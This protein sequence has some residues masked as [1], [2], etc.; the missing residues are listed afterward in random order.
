MSF[1]SQFIMSVILYYFRAWEVAWENHAGT[2][3]NLTEEETSIHVVVKQW[4][5]SVGR[6][7]N[8]CDSHHHPSPSTC[9]LQLASFQLF[10]MT[11]FPLVS[12]LVTL[13]SLYFRQ[14]EPTPCGFR[15]RW[16]HVS[17][18]V[19]CARVCI[20]TDVSWVRWGG[21]GGA[22]TNPRFGGGVFITLSH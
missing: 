1:L 22:F 3:E 15:R 18:D 2:I 8:K 14:P 11:T 19:Q 21:G 12:T 7:V 16:V 9:T 10:L 5:L 13:Y 6:Q 4:W 17:E 20:T